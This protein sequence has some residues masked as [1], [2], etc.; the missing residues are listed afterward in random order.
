[1]EYY[2]RRHGEKLEPAKVDGGPGSSQGSGSNHYGPEG[3]QKLPLGEQ[4]FN[5]AAIIVADRG[6]P[7][8]S[9]A[10]FVYGIGLFMKCSVDPL[11]DNQGIRNDGRNDYSRKRVKREWANFTKALAWNLGGCVTACWYIV[12]MASRPRIGGFSPLIA[13]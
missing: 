5:R 13:R 4:F 11:H 1:M 8:A 9:G 10:P 7:F 12:F 3:V 2:S 6:C